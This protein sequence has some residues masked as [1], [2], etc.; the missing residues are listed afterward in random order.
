MSNSFLRK[1]VST[2]RNKSSENRWLLQ[3]SL[4]LKVEVL[5]VTGVVVLLGCCFFL[6][7]MELSMVVNSFGGLGDF[8]FSGSYLIYFCWWFITNDPWI[9]ILISNKI[10]LS[11]SF[12]LIEN[13]TISFHRFESFCKLT[14]INWCVCFCD[15]VGKSFFSYTLL[16]LFLTWLIASMI[17]SS[18][19]E[20][21]VTVL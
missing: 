3:T 4:V 1:I 11:F 16:F 15:E 18:I 13:D 12:Q 2:C 21:C 7:S 8:H 9:V 20:L 10:R 14:L 17:L 19:F 6:I 5:G